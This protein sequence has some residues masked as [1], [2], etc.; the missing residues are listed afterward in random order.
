MRRCEQRILSQSEKLML[1][2]SEIMLTGEYMNRIYRL[3]RIRHQ[4][5][6]LKYEE[7]QNNE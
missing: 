5:K 4:N 3:E 6:H 7:V 2:R 1:L